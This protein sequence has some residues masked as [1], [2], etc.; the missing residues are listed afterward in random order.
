MIILNSVPELCLRAFHLRAWHSTKTHCFLWVCTDNRFSLGFLAHWESQLSVA[1]CLSIFCTCSF[2]FGLLLYICLHGSYC[3]MS[4]LIQFKLLQIMKCGLSSLSYFSLH[5]W[6]I[7]Y[8]K[9]YHTS[10]LKPSLPSSN[11]TVPMF[12]FGPFVFG[13]VWQPHFE[14]MSVVMVCS[15]FFFCPFTD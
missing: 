14:W 4:D 1:K 9:G 10:A 6:A 5:A 3:C 12:L 15:F 13:C 2:I 8:F 7:A 11:K